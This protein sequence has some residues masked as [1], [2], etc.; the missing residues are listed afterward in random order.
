M[1]KVSCESVRDALLSGAPLSDGEIAHTADCEQC[2]ALVVGDAAVGRALAGD[3]AP[4]EPD[5]RLWAELDARL[6]HERG[7]RAWLRSRPTPTRV[8]LA[9][10]AFALVTLLGFRRVRGDWSSVSKLEVALLV[11]AFALSALFG[12]R[13]ALPLLGA[14]PA[15]ERRATLVAAVALPLVSAFLRLEP[16]APLAGG[17]AFWTQA[18]RC[19]GYGTLLAAPLFALLW[20]CDRGGGPRSRFVH[21]ALACG[22]AAN[23][24]LTLHCAVA[25][26]RHVLVGHASIGLVLAAL[27]WLV[28][29]RREPSP[30]RAP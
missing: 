13:G 22:L 27:A 30:G 1:S 12:V 28:V 24:A 4:I 23:A 20:L 10:A 25:D 26:A 17:P 6:E 29:S 2:G 19:F 9:M 16:G 14:S 11:A 21:A 5:P 7:V 18:A 15:R 8:A 3:R